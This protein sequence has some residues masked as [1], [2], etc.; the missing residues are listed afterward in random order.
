MTDEA[1]RYAW[2]DEQ[3]ERLR[4]KTTESLLR[5]YDVLKSELA[6][7]DAGEKAFYPE[8]GDDGDE[9]QDIMDLEQIVYNILLDRGAIA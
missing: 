1:A 3:Y 4:S 6:D 8:D 2:I 5:R 9:Y 7:W